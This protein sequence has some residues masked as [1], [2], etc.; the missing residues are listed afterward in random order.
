MCYS[1]LVLSML[2][3]L[4]GRYGFLYDLESTL[5]NA[6]TALVVKYRNTPSSFRKNRSTSTNPFG[7]RSNVEVTYLASQKY[8]VPS[9]VAYF[10]KLIKYNTKKIVSYMKCECIFMIES[11]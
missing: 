11:A 10:L 4:T 6:D 9:N 2:L 7:A 5:L 8:L 1:G 3:G